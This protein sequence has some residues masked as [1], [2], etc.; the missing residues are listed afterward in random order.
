MGTETR[1]ATQLLT[2]RLTP[3]EK[4]AVCVAA[5]ARG[6]GPSQWARRLLLKE[7]GLPLPRKAKKRDADAKART[8]LIGE[9]NRIGNNVNQLALV[10]NAQGQLPVVAALEA[11]A[12]ELRS[13]RKGAM[14][15]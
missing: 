11:M 4:A 3:E 5:E 13:L 10:A 14:D 1:R 2:F 6:F 15:G 7:A 12:E 8:R 9:I